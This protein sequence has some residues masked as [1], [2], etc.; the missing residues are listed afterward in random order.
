MDKR[1]TRRD[2]AVVAEAARWLA[3][4]VH[5]WLKE[6]GDNVSTYEEVLSDLVDALK[7]GDTDGYELAKSLERN[8]SYDPDANLVEILDEASSVFSRAHTEAQKAWVISSGAKPQFKPG[9][10]VKFSHGGEKLVGV[11]EDDPKGWYEPEGKHCITVAGRSGKP[12][13]NWEDVSA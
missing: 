5:G 2:A 4:K 12:I 11:I 7:W 3:S 10:T 8:R 1:P 13:V 6:G 9:D